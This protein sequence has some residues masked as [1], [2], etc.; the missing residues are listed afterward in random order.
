MT[1]S[2]VYKFQSVSIDSVPND[3]SVTIVS[4]LADSL[5]VPF[6]DPDTGAVDTF[7]TTFAKSKLP[8]SGYDSFLAIQIGRT[9][10]DKYNQTKGATSLAGS[11]NLSGIDDTSA[12]VPGLYA[13]GSGLPLDATIESIKSPNEVKLSAQ[14]STSGQ[15]SVVF[16]SSGWFIDYSE[17]ARL[18]TVVDFGG[19]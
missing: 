6:L 9:I 8:A 19:I 17:L 12:L 14:A 5:G 4:Y 13:I 2:F 7:I 18:T 16:S 15:T 3:V 1:I 10:R 11:S